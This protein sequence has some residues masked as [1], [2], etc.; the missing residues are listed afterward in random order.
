[1]NLGCCQYRPKR[2]GSGRRLLD[3]ACFG[4]IFEGSDGIHSGHWSIGTLQSD[5]G[6]V[7]VG[8]RVAAKAPI[9]AVRPIRLRVDC[10]PTGSDF[11]RVNFRKTRN[12]T[13]I[14]PG[15]RLI[16]SAEGSHG[17]KGAGTLSDWSNVVRPFRQPFQEGY[18]QSSSSALGPVSTSQQPALRVQAR[19]AGYPI[20][21]KL[22]S[23]FLLN[24]I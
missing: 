24:Y 12:T 11:V 16:G 5:T 21:K 10:R 18:K 17:S 7:D 6:F 15:D 14:H 4:S 19:I 13:T 1:M 23:S 3:C 22:T 2:P 9:V 8:C 20:K